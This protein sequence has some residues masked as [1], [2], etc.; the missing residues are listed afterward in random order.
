MKITSHLQ[1]NI[2]D[3]EN[4]LRVS[5]CNGRIRKEIT[6]EDIK[7]KMK[8]KALQ[9]NADGEIVQS[10]KD[11]RNKN[12]SIRR[13]KNSLVDLA[14]LNQFDYFGTIT[15]NDKWHDIYN[16]DAIL[17]KLSKFFNNYKTRSSADF[18]YMFVPEYG[19]KNKRLHFHFLAKGIREEDLF[20]NEYKHL[21]WL[22]V[23]ERFG[24][25]QITKIGNTEKDKICVAKYC[26]KY[27]TKDNIQI[28][29]HRYFRS[30]GLKNP[31]QTAVYS[32][33]I[34]LSAMD[35]LECHGYNAYAHTR[36]GKTFSLY[37]EEISSF[38]EFLTHSIVSFKNEEAP[39][40][41]RF[42]RWLNR[43]KGKLTL[44]PDCTPC[45]FD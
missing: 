40:S 31:I 28:R 12:R 13:S 17:N 44:M 1:L 10:K 20:I 33:S 23:R 16:P 25:V 14:M 34:A 30:K 2:T 22:P 8:W 6:M 27:M 21:D 5:F 3:C 15:I 4:S 41:M 18:E 11:K 37:G 24:H 29:S 26:S 7:K 45:P 36:Y 43:F 38:F 19:K 9:V 39:V 32:P 42:R 35:W